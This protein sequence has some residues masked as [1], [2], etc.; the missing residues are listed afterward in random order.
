MDYP[1]KLD[2]PRRLSGAKVKI[3]VDSHGWR[4]DCE[5]GFRPAPEMFSSD[6]SVHAG[7]GIENCILLMDGSVRYL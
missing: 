2:Q 5:S 6:C 1:T 7:I 4:M 3:T